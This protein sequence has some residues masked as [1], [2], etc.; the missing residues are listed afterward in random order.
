MSI[1]WTV[2][3]L[4][5][6]FSPSGQPTCCVSLGSVLRP[7]LFLLYA[8]EIFETVAECGLTAHSYVVNASTTAVETA[9]VLSN[10]S[11]VLLSAQQLLGEQQTPQIECWLKRRRSF[12]LER[13][14]HS[15]KI[16]IGYIAVVPRLRLNLC[17]RLMCLFG[18]QLIA[19]G[20]HVYKGILKGCVKC[21]MLPFGGLAD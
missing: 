17:N 13:G 4:A 15:P 10:A 2:R 9:I 18:D 20:L 12:G 14:N 6:D 5:E 1:L 19:H 3:S 21:S 11:R 8:T 7:L 16:L